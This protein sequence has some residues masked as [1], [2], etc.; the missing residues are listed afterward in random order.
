M[1]S[2][3]GPIN[4]RRDVAIKTP[5]PPRPPKPRAPVGLTK[6]DPFRKATASVPSGVKRTKKFQEK[7]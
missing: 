2:P 7:I 5:T 4:R 6:G 1:P 3:T